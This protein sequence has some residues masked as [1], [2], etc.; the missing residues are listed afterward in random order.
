MGILACNGG[1]CTQ[2]SCQEIDAPPKIFMMPICKAKA[3]LYTRLAK[4]FATI[5][6]NPE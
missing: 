6:K 1:P 5:N 3:E 2:P 4:I